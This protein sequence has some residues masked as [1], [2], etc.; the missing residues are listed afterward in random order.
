MPS[1]STY[2]YYYYFTVVI[3]V[4]Q[5]SKLYAW[6]KQMDRRTNDNDLMPP[7]GSRPE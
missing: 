2:Y 4:L 6:M 1:K 5:P 7:S 3:V